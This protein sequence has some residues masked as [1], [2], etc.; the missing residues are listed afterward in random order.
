[1]EYL[2]HP[3]Q[4]NIV[5]NQMHFIV[6]DHIDTNY[7]KNGIKKALN[8]FNLKKFGCT[9]AILSKIYLTK[10]KCITKEKYEEMYKTNEKNDKR[11]DF[12]RTRN[13]Y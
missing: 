9:S 13:F 11:M 7:A 12:W 2:F 10:Y 5:L 4:D 1:M 6:P 3:T 8:F